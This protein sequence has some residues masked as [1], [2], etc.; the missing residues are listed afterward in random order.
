ME[1]YP[2]YKAA[3]GAQFHPDL[4]QAIG[5]FM[6]NI[7][8]EHKYLTPELV[9]ANIKGTE[10]EKLLEWDNKKAAHNWRLQ[11]ARNLINHIEIINLPGGNIEVRA[12]HQVTIKIVS[13]ETSD[14][15]MTLRVYKPIQDILENKDEK[16]EILQ[17]ILDQFVD[18]RV[19]Y[20]P[21]R[22]LDPIFKAI[23]KISRDYK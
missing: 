21:Y 6:A 4:A 17:D 11:Q 15:Q 3:K 1:V 9:I 13:I 22:E 5:E 23:D 7:Y 8:I 18:L 19:K 16:E 2:I 14:K 12:F 20:K 10:L